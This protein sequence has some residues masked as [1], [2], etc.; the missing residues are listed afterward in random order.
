M[1]KIRFISNSRWFGFV[2]ALFAAALWGVSG[3]FAQF[4]F[5]KANFTPQWLVTTRMLISALILLAISIGFKNPNIWKIWSNKRDV[6]SLIAFSIIAMLSV[7]YTY[8]VTIL[9]SNAAT[10]TVLQ[11]VGPVFIAIYL[12]LRNKKA[13]TSQEILAITLAVAGTFLLVTHA[14]I[15]TLIIS[16]QALYWGIASALALA[17]YTLMPV[18]LLHKYDPLSVIS[19]S[20]LIASVCM[21]IYFNPYTVDIQWN[22]PVITAVVFI[23]IFGTLI[24]FYMFL[25]AVKIIGPQKASLLAC[26]EPL[27]ATFIAVFF[28]DTPF[29]L[30]DYLGT[31][32]ILITILLLSKSPSK[33]NN[34]TQVTPLPMQES[35]QKTA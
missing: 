35:T 10:A 8:F 19:W 24:P 13:P 31:S 2:S 1:E 27:A 29:T 26:A 33:K 18:N 22:K 25:N 14:D 16:P 6:T 30:M 21:G 11:Y 23:V 15:N 17:C 12:A 9:H 3:A 28:L 20:M 7:Q 5:I 32:C 4:L 34:T